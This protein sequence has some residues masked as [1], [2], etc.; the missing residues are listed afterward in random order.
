MVIPSF[1][2][3]V[4]KN[5]ALPTNPYDDPKDDFTT[6]IANYPTEVVLSNTVAHLKA[7]PKED[8][9]LGSGFEGIQNLYNPIVNTLDENIVDREQ[10]Q[11]VGRLKE[12]DTLKSEIKDDLKDF[13]WLNI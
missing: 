11:F 7:V 13:E 6:P 8:P 4:Y 10:N 3:V 9:I 5:P 1:R 12:I 2:N